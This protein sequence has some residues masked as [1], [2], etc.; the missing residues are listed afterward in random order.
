MLYQFNPQLA[1][2]GSEFTGSGITESGAYV[3]KLTE[4]KKFNSA[5]QGSDACGLEFTFER[6]DGAKA[7]FLQI[8]EKNSDGAEALGVAQIHAL[9]ACL[10]LRSVNVLEDFCKPVGLILQRENYQN[11]QGEDKYRFKIVAPFHPQN[12]KTA[13][14]IMGNKQAEAVDRIVET[15]VD[16]K[17]KPRKQNQNQGYGMQNSNQQYQQ[18][19]NYQQQQQGQ[20]QGQTLQ[21]N[22]NLDFDDDIPF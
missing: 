14:E 15:L 4:C 6:S 18:Y 2:E 13:G 17:A 5:V 7:R 19:Q 11:S 9:M 8:Y 22:G 16:K 10:S 21:P 20:P 1:V 3:G 12:R